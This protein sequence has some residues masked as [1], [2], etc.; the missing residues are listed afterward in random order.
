MVYGDQA[1]GPF[2]LDAARGRTFRCERTVLAVVHTVTSGTR[3]ADVVPLLE[4]DRRVQVVFT[5]APSSMISAGVREFLDRLGGATVP[6][7]QATNTQFDLAVAAW[8]GLL[9][10]L[11]A[12]VLTLSH[13]VGAG[14]FM[15]RWDGFGPEVAREMAAPDR[16]RLVYRG[17]VIP[18]AIIVP[19]RRQLAQLRRSCPE[20]AEVAVL[21]GDPC[22]DRL[23]ASRPRRE[24]YRNALGTAGR[25]LVVVSSTWGPGSLLERC[26]GLVP[27]L[28]DELPADEYLVAA[29]I[30]PNAW[31]W[32]GPRQVCGWYAESVRRGLLLIPPEDGWRAALVA[33]DLLIG[34]HGSVTC[35][36]AGIGVPVLLASF[37]A[38]HVA[39]ATPPAQLSRIAIRLRLDE[40]IA[41]QVRKA[42][43]DWPARRAV[44][45]RA[46]ITDA[47]GQSAGI[48]R[49][50]MYR[51]M[52][53][54]KPDRALEVSPV[55]LPRP[56][57]IPESFGG[58]R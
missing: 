25:Q 52:R 28:L 9:E 6:W 41:P 19:T 14:K 16:A 30:H 35:Y 37:P 40:A 12:P 8:D 45:M 24:G 23:L 5:W 4:S 7:D 10:R 55:C 3:L 17:R 42:L 22:F 46:E 2:G 39:P 1:Y 47:A 18:S 43:A 48:I 51:L 31:Y 34:D 15:R 36:G 50:E 57:E 26:P 32:H 27:R 58:I 53:L 29:V 20:A 56:V 21:G 11:H 38:E 44:A 13:G 49:G 54:P 33:A